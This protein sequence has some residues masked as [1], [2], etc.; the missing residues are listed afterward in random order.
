MVC[1]L[2]FFFIT[3]KMKILKL[4]ALLAVAIT[5]SQCKSPTQVMQ[6]P[7]P[8]LL[9]V[10]TILDSAQSRFLRYADRTN[11]DPHKAIELTTDW[12]LLQPNVRTAISFDSTYIKIEL[13]SGLHTT[14]SFEE[15]NDSGYSLFRGGGGGDVLEEF[16]K[17]KD[18]I[19]SRNT[20]TNKKVLLFVTDTK[21]LPAAKDQLSKTYAALTNSGLGLDV[22]IFQ[23]EQCTYGVVET[24]KDYGLVLI[25]GHGEIDGFRV[26]SRLD[27]ATVK[28]DDDLKTAVDAQAGSGTAA[29]L[30]TGQLALV[31]SIKVNPT[32]ANWPKSV[33]PTEGRTL[34]FTSD[35]VK[36]LPLM[37]NTI[38]LGNM[39]E[40]GFMT[41]AVTIPARTITYEDGTKEQRPA[42]TI[43]YNPLGKAFVD[44]KPISYYGYARDLPAGTSRSVPD[45]FAATME[46]MLVKR[47]V[48]NQDS[49]RIA[50]LQPDN[51]TEY[52][53]PPGLTYGLR[54]NLY[55]R[56]FGADDYSYQVC[57]LLFTDV[58]DGHL[59]KTACIG[60][61]IWM[62]EN[63]KYDVPGSDCY[64]SLP[65]NCTTYGKLYSRK[66]VMNGA[67]PSSANPS[68]VQGICPKGW[69]LP[70]AAE[71]DQLITALGGT[72]VAGG[73]M[74]SVTTDW[75]GNVGANNSS[76]FTGLPSGE[77]VDGG[78]LLNYAREFYSKGSNAFYHTC[79]IPHPG[80]I[81]FI[82]LQA[83]N[84]T[85]VWRSDGPTTPP[86]EAA[87]ISCR[88]VKDK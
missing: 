47:F 21:S 64:D 44:R 37:P 24:F 78:P 45:E 52:F 75:L 30:L 59:Y 20:I 76:G 1:H 70:S 40:S 16:G 31:T 34:L 11:G 35:Y 17:S 66:Q 60:K 9:E 48:D 84:A 25:D 62:A 22:T 28:S 29:K 10:H 6:G 67:Q 53:D 2:I 4:I 8:S 82:K 85:A 50:N 23:D 15:I 58:R 5:F 51:A 65:A 61:Q 79:S 3:P 7:Q 88:C 42:F 87:N 43:N 69:H 74:K 86:V 19:L 54:E 71:W 38:L 26:G 73:A 32:K 63:L 18:A 39:C 33:I 57:D 77:W 46:D 55:F 49:T 27:F 56:H 14:F 12:L 68:G 13:N 80:N 81:N 36:L 72:A 83:G 41:T